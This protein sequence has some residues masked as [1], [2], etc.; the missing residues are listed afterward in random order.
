MC[1]PNSH[2]SKNALMS[3]F[4]LQGHLNMG[5]GIVLEE[6]SSGEA[7]IVSLVKKPSQ[8]L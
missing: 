7:R 3:S 5:L 1:S 4:T 2:L 6:A 8:A